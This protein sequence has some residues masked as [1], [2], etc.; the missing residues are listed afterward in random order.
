MFYNGFQV[1]PDNLPLPLAGAYRCVNLINGKLYIGISQNIAKRKH[2]S[3]SIGRKFRNAINKYG[4]QNFSYEPLFY[5]INNEFDKQFLCELEAQ[6]IIDYDSINN[7]CNIIAAYGGVG[8]YGPAHNKI[9]KEAAAKIPKE[10]R[11]INTRNGLL[12]IASRNANLTEEEYTLT[13]LKRSIASKRFWKTA[14][15]EI[16][17]KI[18]NALKE[19]AASRT[20]EERRQSALKAAESMTSEKRISRN[21]KI[22]ESHLA[23]PVEE[24]SKRARDRE[25]KRGRKARLASAQKRLKKLT[26]EFFS[27]LAILGSSAV[28]RKIWIN[29]GIINKRLKPGENL[30]ST[31]WKYGRCY[32]PSKNFTSSPSGTRWINNG[33]VNKRLK[34]NESLPSGFYYGHLRVHK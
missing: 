9:M 30:P 13:N 2:S 24:R 4:H 18:L 29:N 34:E 32:K 14:D 20:P 8:P 6:L 25:Q 27:K 5:F 11:L 7:G 22:S 3:S 26:P 19:G 10:Q 16:I 1:N 15:Q 17:N 23:H 31:D 12:A 21:K 33:I 28:E